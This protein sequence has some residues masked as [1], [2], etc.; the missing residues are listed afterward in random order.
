MKMQDRCLENN[1]TLAGKQNFGFKYTRK[2]RLLVN[3][4]GK[5]K[6]DEMLRSKRGVGGAQEP[7]TVKTRT[8]DHREV[9]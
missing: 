4:F 8:T 1:Q 6:Q 5:N 9:Y 7:S 2:R 3:S